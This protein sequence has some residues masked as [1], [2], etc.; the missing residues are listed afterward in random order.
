MIKFME[1]YYRLISLVMVALGS[2]L[3]LFDRGLNVLLYFTGIVVWSIF[4]GIFIFLIFVIIRE[5]CISIRFSYRLV[6][7]G[8]LDKTKTIKQRL[9]ALFT[10]TLADMWNPSAGVMVKSTGIWVY[11]TKHDETEDK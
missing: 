8:V 9:Y 2:M 3:I 6:R 7:A 5:A 1:K 4:A 10:F 11:R